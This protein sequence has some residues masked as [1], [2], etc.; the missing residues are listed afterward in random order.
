M[1]TRVLLASAALALWACV[2]ALALKRLVQMSPRN[3]GVEG[4]A[5]STSREE[6]G[7]VKFR[8][9]RELSKAVWPGRSAMLE[10]RGDGGRI[11][12][13]PLE[14]EKENNTLTYRFEI[15]PPDL[16]RAL[17]TVS[18][19]QTDRNGNKLVGGGTIYEFRLVDY[20][21]RSAER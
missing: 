5:I 4:F 11:V 15:A 2:P 19:V 10:L 18:E 20:V 3:L 7:T 17:L 1:K 9:S 8:V 16:T 12:R 13:R 14:P 6:H 21:V